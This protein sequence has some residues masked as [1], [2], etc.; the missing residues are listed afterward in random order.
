[1]EPEGVCAIIVLPAETPSGNAMNTPPN[2]DPRPVW[3]PIQR[4]SFAQSWTAVRLRKHADFQ[5]AYA[6]SRKR[7]SASMSWFLA[8]RQPAAAGCPPDCQSAR[9]EGP[10]VGL[11]AGK[12]LGKAHERNRIKRRVRE[13]LRRHLDL[14]PQGCDL[15]F[16]PRRSILTLEFAKLEAEIVRI[17]EQ[18]NAEATRIAGW[19]A[20]SSVR[21]IAPAKP[22]S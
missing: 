2:P 20:Q 16:H 8:P 4:Q 6:A 1:L 15:I 10:R 3:R 7:Q 5:R 14:L 22:A 19:Q 17:L 13:A 18:A 21:P 12:V 11:T 9:L